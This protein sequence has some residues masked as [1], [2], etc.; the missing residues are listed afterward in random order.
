M[1]FERAVE[2][3]GGAQLPR[4][5]NLLGRPFSFPL[6]FLAGNVE[7]AAAPSFHRALPAFVG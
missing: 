3:V 1:Y 7:P 4:F 5:A 6:N 2:M